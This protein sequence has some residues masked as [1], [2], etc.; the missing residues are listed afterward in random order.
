MILPTPHLPDD[1]LRVDG[2]AADV[3]MAIAAVLDDAGLDL[4]TNMRLLMAIYRRLA[5]AG[6]ITRQLAP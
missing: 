5:D 1:D 3:L 6:H 4:R 2:D